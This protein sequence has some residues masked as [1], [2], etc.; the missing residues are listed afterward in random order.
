[1]ALHILIV[2][3]SPA[4][5][6]FIRRTT[7][8]IGGGCLLICRCMVL[9]LIMRKPAKF[10]PQKTAAKNSCVRFRF[11]REWDCKVTAHSELQFFRR[12][13]TGGFSFC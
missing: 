12:P 6:A 7:S 10:R 5:R 4:M 8:A 1:M 9:S 3:D 11:L 2:D 13:A